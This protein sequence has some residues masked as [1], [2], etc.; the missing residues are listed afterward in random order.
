MFRKLTIAATLLIIVSLGFGAAQSTL[1]QEP[2]PGF[3]IAPDE[4]YACTGNW[5]IGVPVTLTIDTDMDHGNGYVHRETLETIP[6]GWRHPEAGPCALPRRTGPPGAG[7][8]PRSDL[9]RSTR[10]W[11][12]CPSRRWFRRGSRRSGHRGDAWC[13]R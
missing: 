2:M 7:P 4:G 9:R 13:S 1:A 3:H 6:A 11:V 12:P 8:T 10:S 5:A